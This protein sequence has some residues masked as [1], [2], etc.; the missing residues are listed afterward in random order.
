MRDVLTQ[1]VCPGT[2]KVT[3]DKETDQADLKN[4]F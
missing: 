3:G 2:V 4:F 1:G